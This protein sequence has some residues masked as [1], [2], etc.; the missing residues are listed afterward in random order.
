[1]KRIS[2]E[3]VRRTGDGLIPQSAVLLVDVPV[4]IIEEAELRWAGLRVEAAQRLHLAGKPV[5]EHWRW[6]WRRKTAKLELL[7]YRCFGIECDEDIQG[8]MMVSTFGHVSRLGADKQRPLVYIDYLESAPW[9]VKEMS[10]GPTRFGAV[11][12]RLFE[13][14]VRLS[15]DEEFSGRVGLHALP[16]AISFYEHTCGMAAGN[17]DPDYEDLYW[18][19]LS[20]AA[21]QDFL[22]G[23]DNA[24]Q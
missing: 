8:L 23:Q 4:P 24:A 20:R 21:A 13:A 6:D 17:R 10:D 7:N 15:L 18:Y 14:A 2:T 3:I 16:Q 9:N 19:E 11:G 1:M 5:P 22:G 12:V